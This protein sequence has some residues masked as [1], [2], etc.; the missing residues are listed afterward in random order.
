MFDILFGTHTRFEKDLQ[1]LSQTSVKKNYFNGIK[2]RHKFE[3]QC[4]QSLTVV[5]K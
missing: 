5:F 3:Q 1:I 2:S 4:Q